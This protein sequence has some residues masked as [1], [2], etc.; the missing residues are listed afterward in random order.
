MH[1]G[2]SSHEESV[3]EIKE[4][5]MEK[6]RSNAKGAS[7]MTLMNVA[8][9]V[10]LEGRRAEGSGDLRKALG[11]FTQSSSLIQLLLN[12]AEFKN[13]R[14]ALYKE[15][16]DWMTVRV[17]PG[18]EASSYLSITDPREGYHVQHYFRG[19]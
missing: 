16:T 17:D 4:R 3:A 11:L 15:V 18:L 9:E 2:Y 10:A 7:A 6:A 14:G 12:G 13:G 19:I 1:N 5:A 8:R